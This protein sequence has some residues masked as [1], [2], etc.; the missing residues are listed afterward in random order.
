MDQAILIRQTVKDNLKVGNKFNNLNS[1]G[2]TVLATRLIDTS[3]LIEI[4]GR[5]LHA[6]FKSAKRF[7]SHYNGC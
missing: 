1:I 7:E 4:T 3:L 5:H 6:G 2:C